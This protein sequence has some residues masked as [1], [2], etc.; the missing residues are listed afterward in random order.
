MG[1]TAMTHHTARIVLAAL[2]VALSAAAAPA[3][4]N[5]V[6]NGGFDM[7]VDKQTDEPIGWH[8]RLTSIIPVPEYTDPENKQGRT[9]RV[10]YRCGCGEFWPGAYRPWTHL[11]CPSCKHMNTGLEDSGEK[12]FENHRYVS[13]EPGKGGQAI[14]IST[15]V[16][17][18]NVQGARVLSDL[19]PVQRGGVYAF[20]L[21]V[22]TADDGAT[23]VYVEGFAWVSTD[24]EESE[25]LRELPPES[26]PLRLPRRLQ[27]V[28]RKQLPT[29][30][31][32]GWKTMGETFAPP[33]DEKYQPDFFMV[34]LYYY[35]PRFQAPQP[36]HAWFDNVVLRRLPPREAAEWLAANRGDKPTT[37][38]RTGGRFRH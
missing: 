16:P 9:G 23:K 4:D 34:S 29:G 24:V 21:D 22:R 17:I 6:K 11:Y 14:H 3:A 19:I 33:E 32:S 13:L 25:W 35:Q 7:G 27:R 15:P 5:L 20:S 1:L 28:F 18:G 30:S 36:G 12:Y 10:R 8:T 38:E 31:P 37:R 26:N 2:G